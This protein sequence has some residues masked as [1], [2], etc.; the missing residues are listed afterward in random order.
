MIQ[1]L[2]QIY[3]IQQISNNCQRLYQN[4]FFRSSKYFQTNKESKNIN[5]IVLLLVMDV[6][7]LSNA[8][9]RPV[10][11]LVYQDHN[12][13]QLIRIQKRHLA[14]QRVKQFNLIVIIQSS[15]IKLIR[16][17]IKIIVLWTELSKV[18]RDQDCEDLPVIINIHKNKMI[19]IRFINSTG[20]GF[21]T[22]IV[23]FGSKNQSLILRMEDQED[24]DGKIIN[25]E[26]Q[27]F[28]I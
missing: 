18:C 15:Y 25:V 28:K 24:E 12:A 19:F 11:I 3:R 5:Q 9:L 13:F 4:S 2:I 16:L 7:E 1:I 26:K 22:M 17:L 23:C 6:F 21:I 27:F 8:I 20:P 14:L 10:K